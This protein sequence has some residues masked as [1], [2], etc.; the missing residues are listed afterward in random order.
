MGPKEIVHDVSLVYPGLPNGSSKLV[1]SSTSLNSHW[2]AKELEQ[3]VEMCY[4]DDLVDPSPFLHPEVQFWSKLSSFCFYYCIGSQLKSFSLVPKVLHERLL[5]SPAASS[6][7]SLWA[8]AAHWI[9][10]H[11]LQMFNNHLLIPHIHHIHP[12]T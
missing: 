12:T 8:V 1:I 6:Q 7:S 10:I 4:Y 5:T 3:Q 9:F 2:N 11:H